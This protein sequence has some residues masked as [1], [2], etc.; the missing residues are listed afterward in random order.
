MRAATPWQ[1]QHNPDVVVT[2]M[3]LPAGSAPLVQPSELRSRTA[4]CEG[5]SRNRLL[6][7]P[8]PYVDVMGTPNT[9]AVLP[10]KV[11]AVLG[12]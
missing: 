1:E 12:M 5:H 2:S 6:S 4:Q 8:C 11:A 9:W 3:G 7:P 10:L